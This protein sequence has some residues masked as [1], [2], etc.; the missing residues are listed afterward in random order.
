[1]FNQRDVLTRLRLLQAATIFL[2]SGNTIPITDP[3]GD[4]LFFRLDGKRATIWSVGMLQF[5]E[6]KLRMRLDPASPPLIFPTL[7]SVEYTRSGFSYERNP[8][9]PHCLSKRPSP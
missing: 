7:C 3:F 5:L 1:M 8:A 4:K 6:T 9:S 2:L